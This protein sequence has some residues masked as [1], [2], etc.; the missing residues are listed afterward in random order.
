MP[1][2]IDYHARNSHGLCPACGKCRVPYRPNQDVYGSCTPPID[3]PDEAREKM[4]RGE[5]TIQAGNPVVV[6]EQQMSKEDE[7]Q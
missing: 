7:L 2:K 5:H 3:I 6:Q 4:Q 1:E